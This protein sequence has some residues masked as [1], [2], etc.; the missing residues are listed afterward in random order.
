MLD[1]KSPGNDGLTKEFYETFW[2]DIKITFFENI[3]F[4]FDIGELSISQR[5]S[6]IKLIEKKYR[7][8]RLIENWRPISLL[9]VDAKIKPKLLAKRLKN[10]LS[11][12][13]S[14]NQTAYVNGRFVS[15]GGRLISDIL[16]IS[17]MLSLKGLLLTVDIQK[18][19]DSVNHQFL[20]LVLKKFG[21]GNTFISGYKLY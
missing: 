4:S 12:L 15:E 19:F 6:I 18:A 10:V 13:I 11:P 21:F 5:Q 3:L 2:S 8:K 16:E 1:N 7:D 20:I 14:Y 17:D 9:N